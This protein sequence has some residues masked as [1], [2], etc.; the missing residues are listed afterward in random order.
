MNTDALLRAAGLQTRLGECLR[1]VAEAQRT[2]DVTRQIAANME[3][4]AAAEAIMDAMAPLGPAAPLDVA[5]HAGFA[6]QHLSMAADHML[7]LGRRS[8]AEAVEARATVIAERWASE[9]Q[10][11]R[12]LLDQATRRRER[13][14]FAACLA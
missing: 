1:G 2:G 14:Q 8:E 7:N 13:G 4:A 6:I 11:L 10:R 3:T 5:S 12:L 9:H